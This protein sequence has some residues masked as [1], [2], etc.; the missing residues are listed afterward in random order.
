MS[1]PN[2]GIQLKQTQTLNVTPQL[3]HSLKILQCNQLELEAEIAKM[4]DEN[5][6]LERPDDGIDVD[7]DY[8][9]T[10]SFEEY[11]ELSEEIPDTPDSDMDWEELYDDRESYEDYGNPRDG[12][13]EGFQDDWV[14]DHV[15]FDSALEDAIHL[16]PLNDEEREIAAH[17]LC[18]LDENYFLA[19]PPDKLAKKLNITQKKLQKV[20]DVIK[21]LDPP[22]IASQSI[23]ECLL[24]QLHSLS[25]Y[26][27]SVAN[28]HDILSDYF[29]YIGQKDSLIMKRLALSED[30]FAQ[31]MRLIRALSPYPKI[32]NESTAGNIQADIF[33]RQRMGM[34][35][36]SLNR[37]SRYDIGINEAYAA[38]TKQCKGDEKR[39]M[40]AQLQNAKFFLRALDQRKQTILRVANAIVMQQQD[41]FLEG[42]KALQ[43]LLMRDI[44][45]LLDLAES[46]VSRA[47][48]GK[49]L[50]HNH[51]VVELRYFFSGDL[52]GNDS[53]TG[54]EDIA[55]S[56]V[57]VKARIKELITEEDPKKPLSDSKLEKI[58]QEQGID[59]AR[60]TIAKYRE[61]LGIL[62]TSK[63][64]RRK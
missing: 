55:T 44:A 41:Y 57:A 56:S 8:G 39:F 9:D 25:D 13:S 63:R 5:I 7:S 26:D 35:Y 29:T 24:A 64:K 23:Q 53:D 50:S 16:P 19:A 47:V 2:Q 3:T 22:G 42:D 37:D 61:A 1:A 58:L 60:R 6:M 12:E 49:Y 28:A 21:Y 54:G 27:D 4:L 18:H 15:S 40:S 33:V 31:A 14:E 17:V 43:P 62:P 45:E 51:Q 46:T 38:M 32:P 48:N 11:A 59:I 34:F 52:S 20:I 10:D 36:A 30:E